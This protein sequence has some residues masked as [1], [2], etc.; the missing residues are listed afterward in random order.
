MLSLAQIPLLVGLSA[1]LALTWIGIAVL[2]TLFAALAAATASGRPGRRGPPP[3]DPQSCITTLAGSI[4]HVRAGLPAG[5]YR[6]WSEHGRP[7]A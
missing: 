7:R 5:D 2:L 3:P 1:T 6:S 4:D